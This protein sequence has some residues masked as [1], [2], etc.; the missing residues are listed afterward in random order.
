MPPEHKMRMRLRRFSLMRFICFLLLLSV[1]SCHPRAR[2]SF[3]PAIPGFDESKKQVLILDKE[4]KEISGIYYLADGRLAAN[5]DE[6]GR[7][8][9]ID[10]KDGS[11]ESF[12]FAGKGDYEDILRVDSFFYVLESNGN[13]NRVIP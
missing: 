12:K 7:I 13:I 4:L 11:F 10:P 1:A 6:D 8:F 2:K 9:Y 3:L 5:N